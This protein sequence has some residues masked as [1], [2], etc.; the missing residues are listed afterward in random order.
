MDSII[1]LGAGKRRREG[2]TAEGGLRASAA[3]SCVTLEPSQKVGHAE[4]V[5]RL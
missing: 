5:T 2:G 4:D 3:L 1:V